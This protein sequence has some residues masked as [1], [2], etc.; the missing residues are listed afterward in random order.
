VEAVATGLAPEGCDRAEQA[1][2]PTPSSVRCVPASGRGS[3]QALC[4]RI[5]AQQTCAR[6]TLRCVS[7]YHMD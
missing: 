4:A 6:R 1:V 7:Q 5:E 3:P 2:E